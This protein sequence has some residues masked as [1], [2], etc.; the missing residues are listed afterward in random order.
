[1]RVEAALAITRCAPDEALEIL[2]EKLPK[3]ENF[4]VQATLISC[5]G[6]LGELEVLELIMPY[7]ESEDPRVISNTIDAVSKIT[8]EPEMEFVQSINNL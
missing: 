6:Q 8:R 7:L 2:K 1:M 5:L 3:E 4:I